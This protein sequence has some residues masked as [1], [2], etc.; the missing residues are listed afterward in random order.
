MSGRF[1]HHLGIGRR[2]LGRTSFV[3]ATAAF[4]ASCSCAPFDPPS[5]D[6][7]STTVDETTTTVDDGGGSTTTT[8]EPG[9]ST[10]TQPGGSTTTTEPGSG[11]TTTTTIPGGGEPG[12]TVDVAD[13]EPGTCIDPTDDSTFVE[14]AEL[15]DCEDPHEFEVIDTF[16]IAQDFYPDD[17]YPGGSTI[18]PDAYEACQPRFEAHTGEEFWESSYDLTTIT[19]SPSTWAEGDREIVC[20]LI[21]IDRSPLTRKIGTA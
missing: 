17:A 14:T 16:T 9:G 10:T 6:P 3:I 8:T 15:R 7:T 12:D 21:N 19:P 18:V 4:V 2:V 1:G 5:G 13:L 20:L 11:T